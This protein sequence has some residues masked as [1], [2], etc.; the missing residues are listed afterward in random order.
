MSADALL[1]RLDGVR[2][3]GNGW[4]ARCPAHEDRTASLSIAEGDDG[5]VLVHC[6]AGC[7]TMDVLGAVGMMLGDLFPERVR[8]L[9]K[10]GATVRVCGSRGVHGVII[11]QTIR[12]RQGIFRIKYDVI[13]MLR[14]HHGWNFIIDTHTAW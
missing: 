6:F 8:D 1:A 14:V 5:R 7:N 11:S 12:C 4:T 2:R 9:V 3:S 13:K 10:Q